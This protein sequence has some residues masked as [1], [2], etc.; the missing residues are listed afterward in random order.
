[1]EGGI[2]PRLPGGARLAEVGD[3]ESRCSVTPAIGEGEAALF[4]DVPYRVGEAG[5]VPGRDA[6]PADACVC[7]PPSPLPAGTPKDDE[8]PDWGK[9]GRDEPS[10]EFEFRLKDMFARSLPS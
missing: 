8:E 3:T 1:M 5:E 6:V 4:I 9:D 2:G 7:T 10:V